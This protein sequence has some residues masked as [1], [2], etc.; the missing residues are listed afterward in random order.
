MYKQFIID[1]NKYN[2]IYDK[3]KFFKLLNIKEILDII[4]IYK[5][6][7][8]F[9]CTNCNKIFA[10]FLSI[11][12][13]ITNRV[14]VKERILTCNNCNKL[15]SLKKNYNYHIDHNV[16][17]KNILYNSNLSN[18]NINNIKNINN[19]TINNIGTI[20]NIII[21]VN[22]TNDLQKI[23]EL[24]PFKNTKYNTTNNKL[25]EYLNNPHNA[26]Q[27]IVKDIHCNNENPE[28]MNILNTNRKD[29]RVQ[30]YDYDVDN[31]VKWIIREKDDICELVFDR[32]VNELYKV[33]KNLKN[34]KIYVNPNK[35]FALNAK[36][37]EYSNDRKTRKRYIQI[38]GETFY[39]N[40]KIILKNKK[41]IEKHLNIQTI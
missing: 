9:T 11:K 23:T 18:N 12:Y 31:E 22:N 37:M 33:S 15:F 4:K 29:N 13:H 24:I 39:E 6:I 32:C 41:N 2:K 34:N 5:Q 28:N 8:Q 10:T 7:K 16:C 27:K 25:V 20:N 21:S 17:K 26:I 40:N 35:E 3:I 19:N 14:C 1:Q 30:V 38:V 36:N